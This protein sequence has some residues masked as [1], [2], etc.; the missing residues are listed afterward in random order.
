MENRNFPD[1]ETGLF[2]EVCLSRLQANLAKNAK[3]IRAGDPE[4]EHLCRNCNGH[5]KSCHNY[6]GISMD[7]EKEY[8]FY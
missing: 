8:S 4:P 5:N 2:S 7:P 6:I 1:G 3:K